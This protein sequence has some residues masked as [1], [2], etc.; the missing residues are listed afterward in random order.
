[1]NDM[2]MESMPEIVRRKFVPLD[3]DHLQHSVAKRGGRLVLEVEGKEGERAVWMAFRP[4]RQFRPE[5][6]LDQQGVG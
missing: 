2:D 6:G 5:F 1:M 3:I 4:R